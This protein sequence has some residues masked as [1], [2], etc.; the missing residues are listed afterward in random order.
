MTDNNQER[1]RRNNKPEPKVYV[2]NPGDLREKLNKKRAEKDVIAINII[3]Y[4]CDI[5]LKTR[6]ILQIQQERKGPPPDPA[7]NFLRD[8]ER[9][10]EFEEYPESPRK[11]RRHDVRPSS[12]NTSKYHSV[13]QVL[14]CITNI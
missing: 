13:R 2:P 9:D 6:F 8:P 14:F 3:H 10:G 12:S 7:Y 5:N 11:D 1:P 4:Y